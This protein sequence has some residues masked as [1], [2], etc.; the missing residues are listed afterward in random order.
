MSG[1]ERSIEIVGDGPGGAQIALL[2]N[3]GLSLA[4]ADGEDRLQMNSKIVDYRR[5]IDQWHSVAGTLVAGSIHTVDDRYVIESIKEVHGTAS[6][7][8]GVL[9][10]GV[11]K[12]TV[13]AAN[14][15]AQHSTAINLNGSA[16]T[17]QIVNIT[18]QTVMD[19]GDR[20]CYKTVTNA[21]NLATCSVTIVL[22]RVP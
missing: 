5:A 10:I 11:A 14:S 19:S 3:N 6:D 15:T 18:T 4:G 17:V 16:N 12:G 9:T 20:V 1:K 21:T 8:G 13:T 7:T 2:D 22:K